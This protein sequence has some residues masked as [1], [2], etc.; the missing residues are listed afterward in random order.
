MTAKEVIDFAKQN[1]AEIVDLKF[2]DFLGTWQHFSVPTSELVEHLFEEGLGF[3]GSSIRGWQAINASDMLVVPDSTTAVMDPFPQVP[4]LSLI[5]NIVDPITREKYTRDP[6]SIAQKAEAYLQS[7]GIGDTAYFG[8]EAEFFVFDD[9]RYDLTPNSCASFVDSREGSWN[10]GRDENPNLGHKP[11]H[12]EGYFPVP[13]SDSLQDLR[14]EM[15]LLMEKI[16]IPMECHHHEVAT[17]GQCEIAMRY[18]SLT[19]CGD[20]LMWYKYIVKNVARR[21]NKTATFMPKPVFDDNGSGMHVHQ[22]IWKEGNPLFA[23]NGYAGFSELGLNYIG[24]I[25]K[26]ARAIAAFAAPTTNSYKRLVPG[27]EAPV[28]LA[29][30]SRNRSAAVRIPMYSP[31]PKAKRLEVRFPDPSCNGYLAFSCMLMAGLDGIENK[32]DPGDPLDKDIYALGPEE[33]AKVPTLPY[34][35][36]DALDALEADHEFLLKGD[37]FTQD[38][39]ETWIEYKRDNEIAPLRLRPHPLEFFLYYDV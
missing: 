18:Q 12:K 11:R 28:N 1:N 31:S 10:S 7:T 20:S 35:L 4:T 5:C 22:S 24:G 21:H 25:L 30:S 26:H 38:V 32:I 39:I 15:M 19:T 3:D 9:V 8:P 17:A 27:F 16:G 37:V 33:L 13:P 29:Y 14:T 2:L 23:G 34:T 6:R 36:D